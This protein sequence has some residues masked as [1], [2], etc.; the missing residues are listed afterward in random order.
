MFWALIF[1]NS[2]REFPDECCTHRFE[3]VNVL[4][5][6]GQIFLCIIGRRAQLDKFISNQ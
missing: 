1:F 5:R 4:G 2:L 3:E 6:V